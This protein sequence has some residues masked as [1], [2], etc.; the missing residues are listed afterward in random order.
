MGQVFNGTWTIQERR[1]LPWPGHTSRIRQRGQYIRILYPGDP[2][3]QPVKVLEA[4]NTDYDLFVAFGNRFPEDFNE[5][6]VPRDMKF[7]ARE[8]L[9]ANP[10]DIREHQF[11]EKPYVAGGVLST[12]PSTRVNTGLELNLKRCCLCQW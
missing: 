2:R 6:R 3:A 8:Q 9:A 7:M 5:W 4:G 11:L 12:I 1:E 10:W